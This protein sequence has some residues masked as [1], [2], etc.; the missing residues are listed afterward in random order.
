M[1]KYN[2]PPINHFPDEE[3]LDPI[4]EHAW[5]EV[6]YLFH[7]VPAASPADGFSARFQIR[8]QA[9]LRRKHRKQTVLFFV[10]TTVLAAALVIAWL[11]GAG[12]LFGQL[13]LWFLTIVLNLM[14]LLGYLEAGSNFV[15]AFGGSTLGRVLL[16]VGALVVGMATMT[17]VL[18]GVAYQKLTSPRRV[19]YES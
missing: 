2:L 12:E 14:V 7:A 16:P 10:I 11:L 5:K 1:A 8:L 13:K 3:P 4:K 17:A 19:Y 15:R 9:D 18:W 6:Q